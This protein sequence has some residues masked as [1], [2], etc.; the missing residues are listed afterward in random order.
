M[1]NPTN[2]FTTKLKVKHGTYCNTSNIKCLEHISVSL[3]FRVILPTFMALLISVKL[4]ILVFRGDI[5]K[6][7]VFQIKFCLKR[8]MFTMI[9]FW[10]RK[11]AMRGSRKY[12]GHPFP[13]PLRPWKGLEIP[14]W[15]GWGWVSKIQDIPEREGGSNIIF[16]FPDRFH[17]F[18]T[19]VHVCSIFICLHCTVLPEPQQ[20]IKI[21]IN[22]N[23]LLIVQDELC[24][25][26]TVRVLYYI[27]T[28]HST[29]TLNLKDSWLRLKNKKDGVEAP[30]IPS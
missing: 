5:F 27:P 18:Y 3:V 15:W 23:I 8:K 17:N 2:P 7:F 20:Q 25:K 22:I 12:H 29:E 19:A 21:I 26:I 9:Q 4:K 11:E 30:L 28:R 6:R 1:K 16:F 13:Q 10:V 24:E 14:V